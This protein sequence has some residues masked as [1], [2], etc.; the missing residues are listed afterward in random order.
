[1]EEDPKVQAESAS[2]LVLTNDQDVDAPE[3]DIVANAQR[4]N[5]SGT[6]LQVFKLPKKSAVHDS[7]YLG[8]L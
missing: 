1:M 3:A 6:G 8:R 7:T 5:G 2:L 4:L